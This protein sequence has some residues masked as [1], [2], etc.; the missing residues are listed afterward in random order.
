[1]TKKLI[2]IFRLFKNAKVFFILS[3]ISLS[4]PIACIIAIHAIVNFHH[5]FDS[6]HQDP[7]NL[8]RVIG[9]FNASGNH[10][11]TPTV[12]HPLAS[13]LGE[14]VSMIEDI[15]NVYMLSAQLRIP[16]MNGEQKKI[17]QDNFGF[18][19]S[20]AFNIL[21]FKW[22]AGG[23]ADENSLYVSQT[24]GIRLFGNIALAEMIGKEVI[25]GSNRTLL[26]AGVYGDF[27]KAS[28]FPFQIVADYKIQAELNPYYD[29]K[30]WSRLN[31]GTQ[32]I[33]RFKSEASATDAES[34][35]NAAF[36]KINQIDGY[37]LKLQSFSAIHSEKP[38]NYSGI[39]FDQT[40][41][42]ISYAIAT[43][44][45]LIGCINFINLSTAR[46]IVRFKEIGLKKILGASQR[47]IIFQLIFECLLITLLALGLGFLI[48]S[49]ILSFFNTTLEL[50][51]P[52]Y[53][54]D[55]AVT[56]WVA[57]S[58]LVLSVVTLVSGLYPS[59]LL[60]NIN[61]LT[62]IR[63]KL[64]NIDR[65]SRFPIRKILIALQAGFT[66]LLIYCSLTILNQLQFMESHSMGFET[67]NIIHIKLPDARRGNSFAFNEALRTQ[68]G[69]ELTSLNL[70]SPISKVQNLDRFYTAEIGEERA[71]L[72][73]LKAVDENYFQLFGIQLIAGRN[74]VL[75]DDPNNI[76]INEICLR[77]FDLGSKD[78]A[79]GKVLTL[80]QNPMAKRRIIGVVKDFNTSSL[81]SALR[82]ALM[83]YSPQ[84]FSEVSI[85][86]TNA[87]STF[88]IAEIEK[89]W[90][91]I[92]PES[93]FEYE[94][95]TALVSKQY[96]FV[97][98][99][100][101]STI[102][103]VVIALLTTA[104]GLYGL[105]DYLGHA[106]MK[107]IGIRKTLGANSREIF[108]SL[109]KE[110]L[111]PVL[112]SSFVFL[113]ISYLL[114]AEWLRNFAYRI[115]PGFT[116]IFVSLGLMIGI[117]F[118]SSGR[119]MWQAARTNPVNVLRQD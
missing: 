88:Q 71:V 97:R 36:A 13:F 65:Q 18:V 21:G 98:I 58:L 108:S 118:L 81:Q 75:N 70:G 67:D 17:K 95:V 114:M 64:G 54:S 32:C 33:L 91:K 55:I 77:E 68:A 46:S 111:R 59:V 83:S 80:S 47:S 40:Y 90:D 110:M 27:P 1:M 115:D 3:V 49:W 99:I 72:A 10:Q 82:P 29:E 66:V 109:S 107:E 4:F 31:G 112:L 24:T 5:S 51:I 8:F 14:Q 43:F 20:D 103:F 2:S 104:L 52:I 53:I 35:I 48:A 6:H 16:Q 100:A 76:V 42:W 15:S 9:L 25:L 69:A 101:Q 28:D 26:V 45:G 37:S 60:S 86:F 63:I 30:N 93:V 7:N 11:L 105:S 92:Y 89:A 22:L 74:F 113:F 84:N 116:L 12:P 106:K 62:A 119:R 78:E 87:P 44:L 96:Q 117:I 85:R 79:L 34:V 102:F 57:F 39:I 23:Y 38:G 41:T 50:I 56:D 61:P 19:Q 94:L 73:A